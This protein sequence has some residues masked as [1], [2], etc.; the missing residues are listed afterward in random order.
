MRSKALVAI[1]LGLSVATFGQ[2]PP[3]RPEGPPIRI[4]ADL[5]QIDAVVTDKK[6]QVVTGLTKED[7]E[8]TENGKKQ[9]IS[10]FEFVDAG[11]AQRSSQSK[12]GE[13]PKPVEVDVSPQGP[14]I[15]D[16]RRTFAFVVDDLTI[17]IDDLAYI[18]Q[19]LTNFVDN[20]M[21]PTDLVAII[22]TVG[23]KGL[24]QQFTN[25]K[26]LLRRAIAALTP[27]PHPLNAFGPGTPRMTRQETAGADASAAGALAEGGGAYDISTG[28]PADIVNPTEDINKSFRAFMS[29]G[30]ASF[31]I[32][33]MK[34]LPGRKSMVLVSGG[35]PILS[36][37][38]GT[39]YS[40][41][42]EFF[43]SLVDQAT[44][45]GVAIHT[46]DI[47][48]LEAYR[49]VATFEETPGR[50]MVSSGTSAVGGGSRGQ[51]AAFGRGADD[52]MLGSN[53]LESQQGLRMLS[54]STG[55]MAVLNKNNFNEG[56]GQI[57]SANAGYYLLSYTPAEGK[58]DNKFR[59]LKVKVRGDGLKVHTRRGYFAREDKPAAAPTD[60]R[61]QILAAVKSP[62]ASR[63]INLDAMLLYKA[64]PPSQGTIDIHMVIDPKKLRFEPVNGKHQT[65]FDVA[66]FIFDELGKLRGGFSE[67]VTAD[68]TD[69]EFKRVSLGGL[70][71]A[72]NTMLP[73]G[74][75]QVRLAVHDNKSNQIGTM[76]RYLEVPDLSKGRLAASS[77]LL[78]AAEPGDLK[79]TNP[80]PIS[81]NR[82]IQRNQ[83]LR[84]ATII[85]NAKL[86]DGKPQVRTQLIISQNGQ[87][88]YKEPE[89]PVAVANNKELLKWGQLGLKGVKP[90]RY[91]LTLVIT[92]PLADKSVQT[93]TRSMDF[94]VVN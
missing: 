55:G 79:A 87:E 46:M 30:T 70:T 54:A 26:T 18:R 48:G 29:L 90:G 89:E 7:F 53:N 71:Y 6:G 80:T 77:L 52:A 66:G 59:E 37:R 84:Y 63:D 5:I 1:I 32:D 17:R 8:L 86:K 39:E 25:D 22:R 44:R 33:G 21:Q 78:G 31:V 83:D 73:S 64:A 47:R 82:Q 74:T 60:K 19:M 51:S 3:Q 88:I 23:G 93:I 35:L 65:N 56:L 40:N 68:L 81:A 69:D 15:G 20:L 34:Q 76:S 72:A 28:E 75:Y 27:R 62:L 49:A 16:V 50:S 43:N 38:P 13:V 94:V 12:P 11:R 91:A 14:A 2:D 10:F 24:L 9:Q 85:Y 45:A 57:V 58:F 42:V 92:D 41:I 61:G 67:T 36:S 4:T